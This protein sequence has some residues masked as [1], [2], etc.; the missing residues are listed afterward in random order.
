[1]RINSNLTNSENKNVF[2]FFGTNIY[3]TKNNI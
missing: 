1:M 3:K 2:T